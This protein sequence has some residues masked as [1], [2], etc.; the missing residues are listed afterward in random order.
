M[1]CLRQP[2]AGHWSI[3]SVASSTSASSGKHDDRLDD[4]LE[5]MSPATSKAVQYVLVPATRIV[6]AGLL[7][8][9]SA[10]H[11]PPE[12][13][14]QVVDPQIMPAHSSFMRSQRLRMPSRSSPVSLLSSRTAVVQGVGKKVGS[15]L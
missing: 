6:L 2:A 11:R 3:H 4:T 12:G 8:E 5:T 7:E 9:G 13:P 14:V 10:S 1:A 15:R